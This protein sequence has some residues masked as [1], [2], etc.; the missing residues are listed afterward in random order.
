MENMQSYF[1]DPGFSGFKVVSFFVR[2][3]NIIDFI[4]DKRLNSTFLSSHLKIFGSSLKS[5]PYGN[6]AMGL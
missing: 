6:P 4:Q 2:L 5:H 3:F 1:L